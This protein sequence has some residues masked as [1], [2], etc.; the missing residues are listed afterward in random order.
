MI[1]THLLN[2]EKFYPS[3]R[4]TKNTSINTEA[5][6]KFFIFN[7]RQLLTDIPANEPKEEIQ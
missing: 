2:S 5:L 6:H 3:K 7:F 1:L 4:K